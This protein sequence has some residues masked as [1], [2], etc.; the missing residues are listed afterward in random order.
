MNSRR[1][2]IEATNL[3][4]QYLTSQTGPHTWCLGRLC[5]DGGGSVEGQ[6]FW[7]PAGP[8]LM[9]NSTPPGALWQSS[10]STKSSILLAGSALCSSQAHQLTRG[11]SHSRAA[12][13]ITEM[14]LNKD[15]LLTSQ[16][17][18]L[19]A[20]QLKGSRPQ[21]DKYQGKQF[22][23]SEHKWGEHKRVHHE[24]GAGLAVQLPSGFSTVRTLRRFPGS[25]WPL[26]SGRTCHWAEMA[27]PL[28]RIM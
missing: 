23:D 16:A 13:C 20:R 25:R 7:S 26:C 12:P 4:A 9:Q 22:H 6:T 5:L 10:A 15:C 28:C 27:R 11:C 21:C 1:Q 24:S 18:C 17:A 8:N 19:L 14:R 3:R 2:L